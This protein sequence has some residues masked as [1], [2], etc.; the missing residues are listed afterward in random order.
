MGVMEEPAAKAA[1]R[2]LQPSPQRLDLH[3]CDLKENE[4]GIP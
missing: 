2:F 4:N 3:F 1:V